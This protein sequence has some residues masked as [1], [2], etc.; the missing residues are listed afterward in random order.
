M[1][2]RKSGYGNGWDFECDFCNRTPEFYKG[3]FAKAW[4]EAKRDGWR[5][6]KEADGTWVHR[7][8]DCVGELP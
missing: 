6:S 4:A 2:S 3:D 8:P 7:C 1:S 5:A